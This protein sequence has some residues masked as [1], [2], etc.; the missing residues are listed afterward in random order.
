MDSSNSFE[1]IIKRNI[2]FLSKFT[3]W[4]WGII[5]ITLFLFSAIFIPSS[6]QSSEMKTAYFILA[7][8]KTIQYIIIY[9]SIGFVAFY[10]LSLITK[11]HDKAILTFSPENI[12]IVGKNIKRII[13][14]SDIVTAYCMDNQSMSGESRQELTIYIED[15]N[16][17]ET[18]IKL[19]YYLQADNFMDRFT[20]Y[21]GLNL[22]FYNFNVS[23]NAIN[24]D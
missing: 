22:K 18:A 11:R 14:I 23:P 19:K 4:T 2:P 3:Y 10:I 12:Q 17:I 16:K 5:M 20:S 13:S 8:P 15:K 6:H 9:L 21:E 1:V 7:V 24:E